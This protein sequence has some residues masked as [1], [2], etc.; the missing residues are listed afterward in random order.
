MNQAPASGTQSVDR[1]MLLLGLIGRQDAAGATLAGLVAASGLNK[2][3]VRRLLLA[4]IRAGLV[5][6]EPGS[7][8]YHLG[9]EAYLLGTLAAPRHGLLELAGDQLAALARD[10]GDTAFLSLRR[11][12]TAVCLHREE[13][14]YPIRTHALM[15]GGQH[16]LGVGAGSLA[17]LAALPEA[18]RAATLE[19][20][21]DWLARDYPALPPERLARLAEAAREQ[22][23]ALNPGLVVPDSWGIGVALRRPDGGVAGAISIAAVAQRMQPPRSAELAAALVAAAAR[24]EARLAQA[25]AARAPEKIDHKR[26]GAT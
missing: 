3:T 13:G 14:S 6:Q 11:G 17:M 7:R 20:N 15:P 18:E 22:G 1:A 12:D 24:I 9:Q 8:A 16:P 5:E 10:S 2:P 19:H 21:R 4:L 25:Y 26:E 23:H